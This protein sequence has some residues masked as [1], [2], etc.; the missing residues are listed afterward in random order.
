[1]SHMIK[2]SLPLIITSIF[3]CYAGENDFLE[4][5]FAHAQGANKDKIPK[6]AFGLQLL[7]ASCYVTQQF[8]DDVY[9]TDTF[10]WQDNTPV[11]ESS[12]TN[13]TEFRRLQKLKSDTED[14]TIGAL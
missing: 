13:E 2:L 12:T 10:T 3:S 14:G 5:S 6:V 4:Q 8:E 7:T 1:M 11:L 9:R